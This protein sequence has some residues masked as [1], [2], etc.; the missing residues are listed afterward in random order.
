[1][2]QTTRVPAVSIGQALDLDSTGYGVVHSAFHHAV[3]LTI[4]AEMWTLLAD[5]RADLPFGV[6]VVLSN[7]D[8]LSLRRGDRVTVRAGFVGV[9]SHLVADCRAAPRW[10][11]PCEDKLMPGLERRLAV[12]A[13]AVR[14][15]SWHDSALMAHAVRLAVNDAT[16]LGAVLAE[17]VGRGPGLTPSGD[18]V[19]VGILAVLT[20]PHSGESGARA[21][22]SL[23]RALLP[24][25]SRTTDV[26]RHLLRQAANGLFCRDLHELICAL[27][28]ATSAPQLSAKVRRVI[29]LGATSGGDTCEGLLAFAPS[30]FERALA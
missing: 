18:D 17:V 19:L 24:L 4:R 11:P 23:G 30:Y 22:E 6:R 10:M 1:V 14:N 25:L 13:T 26:S 27:V 28:G 3:N 2:S 9:G 29:E 21:V 16:A 5:G 7:F 20:S 15:R 12:V 8:G